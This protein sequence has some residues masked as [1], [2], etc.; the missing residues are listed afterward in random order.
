TGVVAPVIVLP[1]ELADRQRLPQALAV[2]GH[3]A[4]HLRARDTA[5]QLLFAL[6]AVPMFCH[7]LFWWLRARVRFC[8]EVLADAA[9]AGG[10]VHA[11]VRELLDLAEHAP[12]LLPQGGIAIFHRPSDFYRRIQ[13]LLQREGPLSPSPSRAR[14]L[15]QLAFTCALVA[16]S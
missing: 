16:A 12:P 5:V 9:A 13:M 8:A 11:Y 4:A 7:P 6:L 3:E 1:R 15:A 2:L 14:T 10:G